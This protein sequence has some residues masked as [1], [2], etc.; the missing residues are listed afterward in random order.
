MET[1]CSLSFNPTLAGSHR[2]MWY[3]GIVQG[4]G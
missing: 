3:M 2:L 1:L 4:V